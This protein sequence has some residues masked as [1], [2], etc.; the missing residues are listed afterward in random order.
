MNVTPLNVAGLCLTHAYRESG[1]IGSAKGS[2]IA[3]ATASVTILRDEFIS[4]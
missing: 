2:A 4:G 3:S 1:S